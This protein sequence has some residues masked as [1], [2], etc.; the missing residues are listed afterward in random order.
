MK[1]VT[2]LNNEQLNERL[3]G[4]KNY[5]IVCKDIQYQEALLDCLEKNKDID[6]IILSNILPGEMNIYEF[7]NT[8]KYKC[9]NAKIY[10]FLD[11]KNDKLKEFLIKKGIYNI[12]INNEITENEFINKIEEEKTEYVSDETKNEYKSKNFVTKYNKKKKEN[13]N[14]KNG[15]THHIS[16]IG[17]KNVGKSTASILLG[18]SNKDKRS[19]VVEVDKEKSDTSLYI[20]KKTSKLIR[21]NKNLDVL[22]VTKIED[23]ETA[24]YK[25]I[26]FEINN[27]EDNYKVLLKSNKIIFLVEPTLMGIK[28]S[29]LI[30]EKII[31]KYHIKNEKILILFNKQNNFSISKNILK[32]LFSDFKIIGYIKQSNYY[33]LLENTNFKIINKSIL[34]EYEKIIKEIL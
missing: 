31:N 12:Y 21:F 7:I 8:I 33:T 17:A 24:V 5:E 18:I 4:K 15:I 14:I 6:I 30:L 32:Q 11:N 25:N 13:N 1:I 9:E 19:L 26:F 16:V 20:G 3:Q 27:I 23:K 10:I 29:S 34:K 22:H 28:E 2:A